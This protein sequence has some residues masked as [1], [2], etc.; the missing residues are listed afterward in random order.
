MRVAASL[1]SGDWGGR[2]TGG[3]GHGAGREPVLASRRD[4][5]GFLRHGGCG[6]GFHRP[7]VDA[8]P[9]LGVHQRPRSRRGAPRQR[10][11]QGLGSGRALI[12]L[13]GEA[14]H[15]EIGEVGGHRFAEARGGWWRLLLDLADE[16]G[17]DGMILEQGVA[18]QEPI[19]DS[20]QGIEV[21]P[22]IDALD[23]KSVV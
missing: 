10:V 15:E 13:L 19:A 5:Q 23:R 3:R 7:D 4:D 6:Q 14:A 21:A 11:V 17:F 22:A 9:S 18:R 8:P 20:S 2:A 12:G 16:Q 1:A